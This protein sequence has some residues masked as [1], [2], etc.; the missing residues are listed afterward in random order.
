MT[1]KIYVGNIS[2]N[3]TE[4]DLKEHFSEY[5]EV[6]KVTII[7]DR[8]TGR[9]KGFGFVEMTNA[10]KAVEAL[11]GKELNGRELRIDWAVENQRKDQDKKF[12]GQR[13]QKDYD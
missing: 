11:N 3:T 9:S 7:K 12:R 13:R 2:W 1:K 6:S 5:G 4:D 10:D 8:A